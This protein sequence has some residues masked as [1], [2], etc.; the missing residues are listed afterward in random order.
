MGWQVL[1]GGN[2][3]TPSMIGRSRQK[4]G[5]REDGQRKGGWI[6]NVCQLSTTMPANEVLAQNTRRH[7][8]ELKVIP[9][10]TKPHEQVRAKNDRHWSKPK[11]PSQT[12]RPTQQPVKHIEKHDLGKISGIS[13]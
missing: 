6:K 2:S 4:Q 7:H 13:P 8:E 3:H 12:P 5:Q 11:P 10:I 9:I 1:G